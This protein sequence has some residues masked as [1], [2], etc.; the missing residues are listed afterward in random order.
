MFQ[1]GQRWFSEAEPELGLGLIE[2]VEHKTVN[3]SFP[4]AQ[5]QRT[6]GIKTAP[7]KRV[8]YS[9]GENIQTEDNIHH[10][11]KEVQDNNGVLFYLTEAGVIPEMLLKSALSFT[12]PQDKLFAGNFDSNQLFELRYQSYLHQRSYQL[13]SN[14]GLLG[15]RVKLLPHQSYISHIVAKRFAPRVMLADEVGLGK[16][17]EAGLILKGLVEKNRVQSSLIIVPDSLVYQWYFELLYK[18]NLQC[19]VMSLNDE[20]DIEAINLDEGQ[21]YII[22]MQKV[23]Q[24]ELLAKNI[25]S[26][27]WDIL[28]V[29]E[30]HQLRWTQESVSQEYDFVHKLSD[31]IPS[32][33]LLSATPEILGREG[34]FSR[35]QILDKDK[36]SSFESFEKSSEEYRK[37]IPIIKNILQDKA[38]EDDLLKIFSTDELANLKSKESHIQ[39]LIDRHGTGRVYFRNTREH[40]EKF[41][42]F[43]PKRKLHSYPL[44]IKEKISDL[45]VFKN[46]MK[47]L[48]NLLDE[49]KNE[50][51]LLL[52]HSKILVQKIAQF[53]K[54]ESTI[55]L[56]L[57]HSGQSLMERDRQAAYFADESG[58]RILL[59]TEIG[60]EGRNFEFAHHLF[61][62]D[63]P[64]VP[65]QLEQRIG[66]LDRI[67]QSK[68][69]N[70]HVPYVT[71]SFEET[72]FRWY[73]DVIKS[74]EMAPKGA[75][76]FYRENYEQLHKL[77]ELPFHSEN[78]ESFIQE[79]SKGYNELCDKLG[80]G[81]DLLLD[82]NSF[83]KDKATE[84]IKS[85]REYAPDLKHYI[86]QIADAVGIHHED[87][88][89]FSYFIRPTDNMF[90][91]SYP[92][93]PPDGYSYTLDRDMALIRDDLQFMSWEHPLIQGSLD[94][95]TNSEIGNM[96]VVSHNEKLGQNIFFEFIFKL[97]VIHGTKSDS[98]QF[99]PITPLRVL[100]DGS[101]Q[102]CT[103]K[104][105]KGK[106][107]PILSDVHT[108]EDKEKVKQLPKDAFKNLLNKA[109]TIAN[110][111]AQKYI[112]KGT[113]DLRLHCENEIYR[114]VNLKKVNPLISDDEINQWRSHLDNISAQIKDA[115]IAI[116]AIRVI[117]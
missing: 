105:P 35:L 5:E 40:L 33:I 64:K 55:P 79:K 67:G 107:D 56:A 74:F 11:V 100:L 46:K 91:P 63:L 31:Q 71:S 10:D 4:A 21:H 38:S 65:E 94:L 75:T 60:S 108:I 95:F 53:I 68:N 34:H 98:S 103:Q 81:Q 104:Y 82:L 69:I 48:M 47:V 45:I 80:K 18:F 7:L 43:F 58:A 89:H 24:D 50:K 57:F 110:T 117:I 20:L 101:G 106:L 78:L 13:F 62:F 39:A 27:N 8:T 52:V 96:T 51:I 17:I 59:C 116:D 2:Q 115:S 111:R 85:V 99:L 1:Q 93:L 37:I 72:L 26:E 76:V 19:K 109:A 66:R 97:E 32:I 90:M 113:E 73:K 6:Y 84:V 15:S 88:N 86:E 25:Q 112:M 49:T 42:F 70:I 44:E 22:S 41:S 83:N 12:K 77:I 30:A 87:L 14:K 29:D 28:I 36:F 9:P 23:M 16:T 3:V 102:D 92:A 61:L 54:K 114:L